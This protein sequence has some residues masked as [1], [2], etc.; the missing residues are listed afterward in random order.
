[1]QNQNNIPIPETIPVY[2][3]DEEVAKFIV[4]QQHYDLFALLLEKKV[5]EQK[6]CTISLNFDSKGELATIERQDFLF[7]RRHGDALGPIPA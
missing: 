6:N 3:P 2:M 1:M 7:S 4:F 5:F